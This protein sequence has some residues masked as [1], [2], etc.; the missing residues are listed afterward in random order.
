MEGKI[1]NN[2][3]ECVLAFVMG[4]MVAAGFITSAGAFN[5]AVKA[6]GSVLYAIAGVLNIGFTVFN[7]IHFY[8]KY[9]KPSKS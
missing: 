9:L 3:K 1:Q 5:F 7:T 8:R 6:D 2:L 4:L